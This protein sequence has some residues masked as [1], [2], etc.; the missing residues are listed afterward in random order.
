MASFSTMA[1]QPPAD[2]MALHP[3]FVDATKHPSVVAIGM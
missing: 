1:L 3:R 2:E